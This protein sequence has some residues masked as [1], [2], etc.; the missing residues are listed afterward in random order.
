V[1][2]TTGR[3]EI[4]G[5]VEGFS[6]AT[7]TRASGEVAEAQPGACGGRGCCACALPPVS[8]TFPSLP[9]FSIMRETDPTGG[10]CARTRKKI[11]AAKASRIASVNASRRR[12][13]L[14]TTRSSCRV[15]PSWWRAG[16]G[17]AL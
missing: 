5:G 14:V 11:S 2:A 10:D 7:F 4:S 3:G 12:A 16:K 9:H 6:D 1:D 15:V 8:L 13:S 17:H